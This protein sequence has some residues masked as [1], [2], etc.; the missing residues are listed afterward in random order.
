MCNIEIL[1]LVAVPA[2][3]S[4]G[5]VW[6]L[7]PATAFWPVPCHARTHYRF[8][9]P[10]TLRFIPFPFGLSS[11]SSHRVLRCQEDASLAAQMSLPFDTVYSQD[12]R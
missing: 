9:H 6:S 2:P 4:A 12:S 10:V 7:L 3:L 11:S 5:T 1:Q 8:S